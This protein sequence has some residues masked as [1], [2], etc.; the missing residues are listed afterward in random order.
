M[1]KIFVN[2]GD[3]TFFVA[4]NVFLCVIATIG[5]LLILVAL[6]KVTSIKPPTKLLFQCLAVTDLCVGLIE[7]PL[8]VALLLRDFASPTALRYVSKV[9]GGLSF[10]LYGV[11]LMTATTIG[12]DR[13]LALILGLSYKLTVTVK[14]VR[15]VVIIVWLVSFSVGFSHWIAFRIIANGTSF[16]VILL[17]I[18]TSV[19]SFTK[20][21]LKLRQQQ[22]QV[23]QC[24]E[25]EQVNGGGI[26]LN[27]AR[28]KKMVH[29]VAW[30]QM[31]L[32]V[33]YMP[34]ICFLLFTIV[35][36]RSGKP[37]LYRSVATVLFLN[38]SV[39]PILYCWRIREVKKEVKNTLKQIFQRSST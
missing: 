10:I 26:P 16:V 22:A 33:C 39:N 2:Q 1:A 19:F 36:Q 4:L 13:L 28:Y 21:A 38:S 5:N 8:F 37:S 7:Q 6:R 35:T 11:S 25:Q 9:Y 3:T 30:L 14:R 31:A 27:I 24:V 32:I 18:F 20:I 17:C 23:Q 15:T 12:I 34:L 29:S